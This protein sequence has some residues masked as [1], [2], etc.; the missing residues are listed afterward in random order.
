M[1]IAKKIFFNTSWQLV[2]R[3]GEIILGIFILGLITR[4]LGQTEYGYYTT[5]V[6]WLQFWIVLVDLGLYL[7]LLREIAAHPETETRTINAMVTLRLVTAILFLLIGSVIAQFLPYA[8][9]IKI[10]LWLLIIS[11]VSNS[12]ITVL[13]ALFQQRL[14]M[15]VVAIASLVNKIILLVGILGLSLSLSAT[16]L[17][18]ILILSSVA[19]L[20]NLLIVL[21][22]TQK[23][24]P[25]SLSWD[26]SFWLQLLHK[27]WPLA[28]TTALNLIY[29]KLDTLFLSWYRPANEVGLY[30]ASYRVL[31]IITTFPHM[32]MGLILPLLT[33]AWV[34]KNHT[35]LQNLWQRCFDFF[36]FLTLPLIAGTWV[37][38]TPI[39]IAIA[40][41]EFA[42]SGPIVKVLILATAAIFFGTLYTYLVIVFDRQKAMIPYFA[43]AA[44]LSVIGYALTIPRYSYWGAAWMTVAIEVS[45]IFFAWLTIRGQL[46]FR[47]RFIT[48][49]KLA[50]SSVGMAL[51]LQQLSAWPLL[52]QILAGV[53]IYALL[54]FLTR[55]FRWQDIRPLLFSSKS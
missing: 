20:I 9:E 50:A 17:Y 51:A 23:I 55:A 41:P 24:I 32:F 39:M 30:G 3:L 18:T 40:G 10:G 44:L 48:T 27:T 45:I 53:A 21:I 33:A 4:L 31:E 15:P 11:Y 16:P 37:L 35:S 7:T 22:A 34:S 29:F 38:A 42:P 2:S 43:L 28:V 47:P 46:Q 8:L 26:I 49:L 6:A 13:T 1:S 5:I 52:L 14:R 54:V 12:I 25:L 19:S 36:A